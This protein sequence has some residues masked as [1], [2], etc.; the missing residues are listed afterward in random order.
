MRPEGRCRC[1]DRILLLR[2]GS[3]R[4]ERLLRRNHAD[5]EDGM[6]RK[7]MRRESCVADGTSELKI[8][9]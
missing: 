9:L 2:D 7:T 3:V 8:V 4:H 1:G 6:L 5:G